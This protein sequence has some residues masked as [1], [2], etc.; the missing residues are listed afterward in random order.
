MYPKSLIREFGQ[1]VHIGEKTAWLL[2]R[3]K[4]SSVY[5]EGFTFFKEY[6]G[7]TL[8]DVII[9]TEIS[10]SDVLTLDGEKYLVYKTTEVV[11]ERDEV[12]YTG[13]ILYKDDFVRD[14]SF[15]RQRSGEGK[16]K[17]RLAKIIRE[18]ESYMQGNARV[19]PMD[20]SIA[21]DVPIYGGAFPSHLVTMLYQEEMDD[22][23]ER[24]VIEYSGV[25]WSRFF[26]V[27]Y[28][29]KHRENE[30]LMLFYVKERSEKEVE[31]VTTEDYERHQ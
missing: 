12:I 26:E 13:V 5:G 30:N 19:R 27:L 24:H 22:V 14:V 28:K 11:M 9:D 21:V 29:E 1:K 6:T 3:K 25:G 16:R 7:D 15:Y 18:E 4:I 17:T 2:N 20:Q 8:L 23:Q 10:L 31:T